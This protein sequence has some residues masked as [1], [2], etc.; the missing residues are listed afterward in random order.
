MTAKRR[1]LTNPQRLL[2]EALVKKQGPMPTIESRRADNVFYASVVCA[3][4]L[5]RAGLVECFYQG[6]PCYLW[7]EITPVGRLALEEANR[8]ARSKAG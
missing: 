8:K 4:A 3:N 1:R 7:V 6:S 2:L 5:E